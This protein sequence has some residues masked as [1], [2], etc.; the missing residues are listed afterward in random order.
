[1][2]LTV[3]A[4]P[5]AR[6]TKIVDW[7]DDTTVVIAVAAPANEGKANAVLVAFLADHYGVA[8]SRVRIVRGATTR[9]KHLEIM[10]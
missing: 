5:G 3:H 1:M 7:L 6:A 8:K 9:M 10:V 4:K 2:I